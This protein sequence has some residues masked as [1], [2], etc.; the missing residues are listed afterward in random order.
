MSH[1]LVGLEDFSSVAMKPATILTA[2]LS[3]L[4]LLL[5]WLL[6]LL[7]VIALPV[8]RSLSVSRHDEAV[9]V[10]LRR[11]NSTRVG[12]ERQS[13]TLPMIPKSIGKEQ[14]LGSTFYTYLDR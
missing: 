10:K 4:L 11:S 1:N 8:L 6:I 12:N 7:L 9:L 13:T 14:F 2:L 3:V 5:I